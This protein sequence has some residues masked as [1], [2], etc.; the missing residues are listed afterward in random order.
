MCKLGETAGSIISRLTLPKLHLATFQFYYSWTST[1]GH[2]STMAFFFFLVDSP[3]IDSCFSLSTM[4]TF[5]CPQGGQCKEFQLQSLFT[6]K[7]GVSW[8]AHAWE[9][10]VNL[11]LPTLVWIVFSEKGLSSPV[12]GSPIVGESK[13]VGKTWKSKAL[14]KLVLIQLPHLSPSLEQAWD[15]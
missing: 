8:A 15:Q 4:A 6:V 12:P 10:N 14:K 2:F 11:A 1:N 3:Y 13:I 9:V 7:G 5:F